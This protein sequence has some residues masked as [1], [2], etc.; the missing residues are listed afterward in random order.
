MITQGGCEHFLS[1]E[2]TPS[3]PQ[4][5]CPPRKPRSSCSAHMLETFLTVAARSSNAMVANGARSLFNI[6]LYYLCSRAYK[7]PSRITAEILPLGF[8][9]EGCDSEGWSLISLVLDFSRTLEVYLLCKNHLTRAK[10]CV[11]VLWCFSRALLFATPWTVAHQA[12]LS[13]GCS[14]Q[15]YWSGLPCPFPVDL[16]N[17]G[18]KIV[19]PALQADSS[20][21]EPPGKPSTVPTGAW[22]LPPTATEIK[23]RVTAAADLQHFLKELGVGIRKE[24]PCALGETARTGLQ[25]VRDFQEMSLRAQFLHL[26][27]PRKALRSLTVTPAARGWGPASVTVPS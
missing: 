24:A 7:F 15:D 26:L 10:Q 2:I 20:L 12:P 22:H 3:C 14:R 25:G 23:A 9:I 27:I 11:C 5:V 13:M 1:T 6:L 4:W 19:S 8:Q 21:L 16:P 17:P 18:I